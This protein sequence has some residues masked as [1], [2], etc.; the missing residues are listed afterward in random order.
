VPV[1]VSA[2][3]TAAGGAATQSSLPAGTVAR[4]IAGA[5]RLRDG[6]ISIPVASVVAPN[7]ILLQVQ[8]PGSV[9]GPSKKLFKTNVR[10][11]DTRGYVVRGAAVAIRSVPGG[12]LLPAAHKRS[13]ADGRTAFSLR[14]SAKLAGK[15]VR[16]VV[17][18]TDPRR[19]KAVSASR[20][21]RLSIKARGR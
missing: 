1:G 4:T 6:S 2:V 3:K 11:R 15:R 18:A 12:M 17:T 5:V 21:V 10:V 8:A 7:R 20:A 16:L 19:P 9:I 13:A 14:P